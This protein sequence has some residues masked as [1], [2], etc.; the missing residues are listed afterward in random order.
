[1]SSSTPRG[2]CET[3]RHART[4]ETA[5]GSRFVLCERSRTDPR[6][7]RY[8]PLPVTRCAGFEAAL[9]ADLDAPAEGT[10]DSADIT[11]NGL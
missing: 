3:C 11:K 1:M 4:V 10:L 2:L 6:F 5:R 8:P 9:A 7:P